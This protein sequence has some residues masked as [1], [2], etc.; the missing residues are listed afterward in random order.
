MENKRAVIVVH[1]VGDQDNEGIELKGSGRMTATD[2][3]QTFA[4][5][6]KI[7]GLHLVYN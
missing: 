1:G 2:P 4:M 3:K 6:A 5:L 7:A